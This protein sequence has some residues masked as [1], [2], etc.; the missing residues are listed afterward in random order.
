MAGQA[1]PEFTDGYPDDA[2]VIS[3]ATQSTEA[4]DTVLF[5]APRD[6]VVLGCD[7]GYDTDADGACTF[8]LRRVPSSLDAAGVDTVTSATGT[9]LSNEID[10]NG[11]GNNKAHSF[12]IVETENVIGK[13]E[14]LVLR[15]AAGTALTNLHATVVVRPF[16]VSNA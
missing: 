12:T 11:T 10:A 6:L 15:G 1:I 16:H 5:I 7:I 2:F 14:R 8:G 9:L 4:A 13:G 3:A